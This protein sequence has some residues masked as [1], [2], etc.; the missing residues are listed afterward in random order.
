MV[1]EAGSACEWSGVR[2]GVRGDSVLVWEMDCGEGYGC[3]CWLA[4]RKAA[5]V[6]QHVLGLEMVAAVG[7]EVECLGVVGWVVGRERGLG[8]LA[9]TV[10]DSGSVWRRRLAAHASG[11]PGWQG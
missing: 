5:L 7:M 10:Q 3:G 11:E 6:T 1:E 2:S 4:A 8:Q 9:S